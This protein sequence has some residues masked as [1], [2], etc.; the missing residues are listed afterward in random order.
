MIGITSEAST[1]ARSLAFLEVIGLIEV[2]EVA[3]GELATPADITSNPKNLEFEELDAPQI[4]RALPD[5][6][7]AVSARQPRVRG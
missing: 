5:V 1:L 2:G 7:Y 6:D 3:E 4:P